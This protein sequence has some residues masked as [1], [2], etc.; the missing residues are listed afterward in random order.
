M[1]SVVIR[2]LD[3]DVVVWLKDRAKANH[4]TLEGEIRSILTEQVQRT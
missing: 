1:A 4:R 2:K 3:D